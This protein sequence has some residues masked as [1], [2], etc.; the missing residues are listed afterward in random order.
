MTP[1]RPTRPDRPDPIDELYG[2]PGFLIRRAD[3][4]ARGVFLDAA[5]GACTTTQYGALVV[6]GASTDLDQ[7]SLSR[8]LGIDRSTTA[9]VV[10]K[11]EQAGYLARSGDATDRRRRVLQLTPEGVQA[12]DRLTQPAAQARAA[13]LAA[14]TPS[15]GERLTR[16]LQVFVAAFNEQAR[17]PISTAETIPP[18]L[19]AL[20]GRP[21]FLLR[22]A[23]QIGVSLFLDEMGDE[24]VTTTQFGVLMIL[25]HFEGLDQLEVSK[26]VGLDRTTTALVVRKLQD[27]GFA[28]RVADPADGRRKVI[29]LTGKGERALEALREPAARARV[30]ALSVFDKEQADTFLLLLAKIVSHFNRSTR[31]PLH[32][33]VDE[34]VLESA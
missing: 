3:Q 6:L 11:L 22:R 31:A 9:L 29:V 24:M 17:A 13:L 30:R 33:A 4:I 5:D 32:H 1:H 27:K 26:K 21:G 8:L 10:G 19:A 15:E 25:R 28:I 2:R 23:H 16:L 34:D 7:I 18:R 14:L 20:Y 12:L